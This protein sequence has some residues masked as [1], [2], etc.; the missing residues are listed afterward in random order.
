MLS[1]KVKLI[2]NVFT[3]LALGVLLYFSWPQIQ[4]GL[5]EIGGARW[6]IIFLMI[7]MQLLNYYAVAE[8]YRRQCTKSH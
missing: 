4:S 8:L 1:K 2:I 6:E 3:L 7:P 5:K